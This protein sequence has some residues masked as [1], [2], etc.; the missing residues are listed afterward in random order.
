MFPP[1]FDFPYKSRYTRRDPIYQV[2]LQAYC[3][4]PNVSVTTYVILE[5][6]P[7]MDAIVLPRHKQR[8]PADTPYL[9]TPQ[10]RW[11]LLQLSILEVSEGWEKDQE[12]PR[13]D[14]K[15]VV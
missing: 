3:L 8:P 14:R 5:A 11:E 13:P 15:S 7:Y 2:F 6:V 10:T 9:Y 4:H 1:E 12:A